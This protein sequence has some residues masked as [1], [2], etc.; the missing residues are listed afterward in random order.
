MPHLAADAEVGSL[1]ALPDPERHEYSEDPI[2]AMPH[3]AADAE[4]GSPEA[5][6]DPECH[7]D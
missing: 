6:T 1:D 2:R 3:L 5:P 7:T 4:V